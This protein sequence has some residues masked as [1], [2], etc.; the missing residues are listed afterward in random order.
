MIPRGSRKLLLLF[1]VLGAAVLFTTSTH[2]LEKKQ[3]K[4]TGTYVR[5][6]SQTTN[7]LWTNPHHELDYIVEIHA[8]TSTNPD[9]NGAELVNYL[10]L[11]SAGTHH[12]YAIQ[13]YPNGDKTYR[14]YE[15]TQKVAVKGD[16][17]FEGHGE[18]KNTF[19]GGT[20]KFKDIR[21]GSTYVFRFGNE[22]GVF[23]WIGSRDSLS[24]PSLTMKK[25]ADEGFRVFAAR[26]NS[27]ILGTE[28][29]SRPNAPSGGR[30]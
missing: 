24:T 10:T 3:F 2:A 7:V 4:M 11:D 23:N 19:L 6:I 17:V 27:L 21:G 16:G 1:L 25:K 29:P 22:G 18:G 5:T 26:P 9:F 28:D 12:G 13:V 14:R 15:G 30:T 8:E 20:G